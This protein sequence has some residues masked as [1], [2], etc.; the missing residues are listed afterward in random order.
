MTT[1]ATKYCFPL[2]IRIFYT[3]LFKRVEIVPEQTIFYLLS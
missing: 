1:M 2:E 3:S